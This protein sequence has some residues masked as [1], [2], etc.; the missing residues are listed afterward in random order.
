[1]DLYRGPFLTGFYLP[2]CP[3]FEAWATTERQTCERLYLEALTML[4]EDQ[5]VKGQYAAAI[6][7]AQRY[8]ETDDLAEDIHR[9]LIELYAATGERGAALRQFEQCIAILERELGVA[10]LPETQ[11]TYRA[12]LAGLTRPG[13]APVVGPSWTTLP[14]LE[15]PQV[16]RDAAMHQLEQARARAGSGQGQVVL[17]SG[18]AGIGKSRLMQ[19]FAT[20]FQTRGLVLTGSGY[21]DARTMPFQPIVEALRPALTGR[22]G[23]PLQQVGPGL[24]TAWLAE[25]SRLLPELRDLYPSLPPP[26]PAEHDQARTRLFEALCQLTLGLTVGLEPVLLCLDDLHWAN[27]TTL[28]WLAHLGRKL[29]GDRLLVLG[30]F[31][32]DEA[33]ALARL[34]YGLLRQGVLTELQL[35]R[36]DE[37]AIGE[38]L[39]HLGH[40]VPSDDAFSRRLYR[41]TG[42]NP[43]FLLE[44]L[45]AL[46]ESGMDRNDLEAMGYP[47]ATDS[48][49]T[50][51]QALPLPRTIRAA[52]EARLERLSAQARQILEAGAVLGL[53]FPFDLVYPTAGRRELETIDGLDELVARQ[54]LKEM[55]DK[56]R[57]HH[58]VIRAAV[59][60]GLSRQRRCVLHRRAAEALERL[61]PDDA[62]ALAWHFE[63]AEERARAAQYALQAGRA[64]RVVYGH[65]EAR[66][67]FDRALSLLEQEVESLENPDTIAA[68]RRLRIEALFERGWALRLLGDVDSYARELKEVARLAELLGDPETLSHLRWRQAYTHR[69]FCR[70]AEARHAAQEGVRLSVAAQDPRLE[71]MCQREMGLAARETGDYRQAQ[72]SLERALSLFEEMKDASNEIHVLGNLS[73]LFWSLREYQKAMALARRA[74]ACCEAAGL[75]FHRRIPLGDIGVAASALGHADQA[76]QCLEQSLSIAREVADRTQEIYC[77]MHLGWLCVNIAQPVEALEHLQAGLALA[78]QIGSCAEQSQ[79]LSGLAEVHRL[80]GDQERARDC[81]LQA[82]E[83]A[84][85]T[86][87]PFDEGLARRVLERLDEG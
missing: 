76:R 11:A 75:P 25:A 65:T 40:A 49:F 6:D 46:L 83:R 4:I 44:T 52:V 60:R 77:L 53:S 79:L 45:R 57:F 32:S 3:E 38:L 13:C 56:Y 26:L 23:H 71:A 8:L 61:Q 59:Y 68:N 69:L 10:P 28:D 48:R 47:S 20:R 72:A 80:I 17:I 55:K 43:F 2:A 30:A 7:C 19:E 12:A 22:A 58:E 39:R 82:L 33:G 27:G 18:E 74:L 50:S 86:A 9:R 70:Y 63:R 41:A 64:A 16:G 54:L 35:E 62:A 78:K 14:G 51:G 24:R 67:Y 36:L 21:P 66:D 15:L 5:A 37:R 87:R 73:T 85:V 81:G 34:R 31:R 29:R 1:V 42:G 84:K